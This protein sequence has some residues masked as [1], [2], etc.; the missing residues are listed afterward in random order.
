MIRYPLIIGDTDQPG[1]CLRG[2]AFAEVILRDF[3][4]CGIDGGTKIFWCN[5]AGDRG[6]DLYKQCGEFD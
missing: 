5:F 3:R 2:F 4:P 6:E 1:H